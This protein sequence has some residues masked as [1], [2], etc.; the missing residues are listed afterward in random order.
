MKYKLLAID[1]DGTLLNSHKE[2]EPETI[3]AIQEFRNKGGKVVICSGRT[4][5]S[6]K[7]IAE[8]VGL[9]EPI[10]AYNG[11]II[12]DENGTIQQV[13]SFQ[14]KDLEVFMN[15][16][17]EQQIYAQF[18]EGDTLLIPIKNDWNK[19][20]IENNIPSLSETGG[21]LTRC[22]IYRKNC[23]I[24]LVE[25]LLE[26]LQKNTP[27][28]S[29]I[30][31]FHGEDNLENFTEIVRE[32]CYGMEIS[33]SLNYKNLEI[34]PINITKAFSLTA[35][36][37]QLNIP[38]FEVAAIGDNYNDMQMLKVAGLGIAMGNAPKEVQLS[39]DKVTET[40]DNNGNAKAIHQFIF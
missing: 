27:A 17:S 30:A 10:I 14:Q 35:L 28:I 13:Q 1:L 25:N 33:T 26:Y 15:L 34:T 11:A 39:A 12:M 37:K 6:T 21:N 8:T 18:Y 23:Q 16:I 3:A 9:K 7:W 4:P 19:N 24:K 29:K 32:Q 2:I 38:L 5:L 20:W 36:A 22:E 31:V 40:N